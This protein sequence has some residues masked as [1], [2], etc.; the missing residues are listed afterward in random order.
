MKTAFRDRPIRQKVNLLIVAASGIALVLAALGLV[1]YDLTT[2]R[3]RALRD[4]QAQAELIRINTTAALAFQD[5]AAAT[6]NLATLKAK[7][8]VASATLHRLDGRVFASYQR[9][10]EN[11]TPVN[12]V[13]PPAGHSF[14]NNRLTVSEPVEDEGQRLGWLVMEYNLPTVWSR[15]PQ[16][17]IITG[18]VLLALLA[19]SLLLWRLLESSITRP[20][21][22]LAE[23]TRA[24]TRSK[25]RNIRAMKEADDEIGHLT[26][27]FNEML[28]TLEVRESALRD[29]TSQL[30][31]AMSVARMSSW[32]WDVSAGTMSWG[33]RDVQVFGE[34]GR[35]VDASLTSFLDVVHPSDRPIV[36]QALVRAARTGQRC[37]LDFRVLDGNG[38]TRWLDMRGQRG[39]DQ[40]NHQGR[41]L[42][43]VMDMT[44]RRQLEEQ[45]LQ[46]QKL[47][48]IGRLAGGVAHDFNNLLTGILG[49][50]SFA[51]KSVPENH[52]ARADILEI[53][54]AG[55]RAASLTGQLL[56][57]ARRQMIAPKIVSL[58]QLVIDME[59]LLRR[60][61]GEDVDME[62]RCARDLWHAQIDPGQFEQVIINLAVNAR[63]AMPNGGRLTIET[64]NSILDDCYMRQ[65]PEVV[66]GEYVM[67]SV[68]D[69]GVGM[70][71]A[72]QIR[73]F[74]PFFTTKE[75]GKGTGLGLAVCYG[76]VKQAGGHLWVYSEPQRG[77]T[78][79]VLLPRA[80]V[81]QAASSAAQPPPQPSSRGHETLLI[82]EDEPVV[83]KLAVRA[84]SEQGYHILEA[85]D[86]PAALAE[87]Q[88][89]PGELHLLI[90]DVVMPGMNGRQLAD[91]LLADRKEM[92]VLYI[93]GYAEHAVVR[94][95]VLE[96]GI[97]FLSKPFD[98]NE[99]ARIVRGV[100][101]KAPVPGGLS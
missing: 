80:S 11:T 9:G 54:R 88:S 13:P 2:L 31:D 43:L 39:R 17:G 56:A 49:Y 65:H 51:L 53:E 5:Q 69:N 71:S 46:S 66:P 42:G 40:E 86:G 25:E 94:H 18:V 1:V 38:Q 35:P 68:A 8:E 36:E 76:I 77:T 12:A 57:Y 4:L 34:N 30:L 87:A 44:D 90:T 64:S 20:L 33:G 97:A 73:V 28:S 85:E 48:S 78:F 91:R 45:L 10:S 26:D 22:R 41:V 32:V 82:V 89:H 16:Y 81:E 19:V 67:L 99:L 79:K 95:G 84:L 59:S 70:D 6:E 55:T 75:Q 96:E 27:S 60:L 21:A 98:L 29:S 15:L 100:L 83:R 74:E 72:T 23:A 63:D 3:P 101:D 37:E 50:A 93:S 92:R 7:R 24:V 14:H 62:T 47:E 58:N 61:I 52:A